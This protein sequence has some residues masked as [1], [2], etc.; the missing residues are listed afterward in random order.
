MPASASVTM[1]IAASRAVSSSPRERASAMSRTRRLSWRITLAVQNFAV[2][3][4]AAVRCRAGVLAHRLDLRD[5][6]DPL[7]ARQ[8]RRRRRQEAIRGRQD[9]RLHDSRPRRLRRGGRA[10]SGATRRAPVSW[11]GTMTSIAIGVWRPSPVRMRDD[12]ARRPG[13]RPRCRRSSPVRGDRAERRRPRR[14]E[15]TG[16]TTGCR[17]RASRYAASTT[18][19]SA[20]RPR[21]PRSR[22]RRAGTCRRSRPGRRTRR[23]ACTT[24]RR[25]PRSG[26]RRWRRPCPRRSCSTARRCSG[27][28]PRRASS[29]RPPG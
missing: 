6:G 14:P 16:R 28:T 8:R 18:A 15:R 1:I 21:A 7:G 19:A 17:T 24:C 4:C 13:V 25:S 11:S 12:V 10:A 20:T 23:S 26:T 27:L 5:V 2:A 3:V 9:E 22:D 29:R